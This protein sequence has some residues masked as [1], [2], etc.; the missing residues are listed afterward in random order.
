MSRS[1]LNYCIEKHC[2]L[3]TGTCDEVDGTKQFF[4]YVAL[5]EWQVACV[6]HCLKTMKNLFW[7]WILDWYDCM[8]QGCH[9]H[10]LARIIC[11]VC[12]KKDHEDG[13]CLSWLVVVLLS[14]AIIWWALNLSPQTRAVLT[15][16]SMFS[17]K[18]HR[19]MGTFQI[20]V[21]VFL[22]CC[23]MYNWWCFIFFI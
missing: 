19:Q 10:T 16:V 1:A 3:Q 9:V 18:L 5:L 13:I 21:A 2:A 6:V 12:L 11:I 15:L 8:L 14:M 22:L 7:A 4:Q 20:P 17:E 23:L